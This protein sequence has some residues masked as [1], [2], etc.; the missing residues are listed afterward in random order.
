VERV[1]RTGSGIL[2]RLAVAA[3]ALG[4]FAWIARVAVAPA[5]PEFDLTLREAVHGWANPA[6]TVLMWMLTQ[7]GGGYVLWPVGFMLAAWLW[8]QGRKRDMVRLA[9]VALG[10]NLLAEGTKLVFAR[11]RPMAWFV[12]QPVNFSFPSGHSLMSLCFFTCAAGMTAWGQRS[13][14]HRVAS[15]AIAVAGALAVGLSRVYLGVH[16]PTDVLGGYAL[17]LAW[18]TVVSAVE[19]MWAAAKSPF[20]LPE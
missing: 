9:L 16:Y 14:A 10:A 8:R 19:R 17:G 2:L 6:L 4:A 15:L 18:I 13:A 11:P 3:G 7:T 20:L 1:S 5:P 12:D